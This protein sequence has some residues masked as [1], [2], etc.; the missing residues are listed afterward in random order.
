MRHR[1][2]T[3]T[4]EVG[5]STARTLTRVAAHL[6]LTAVLVVGLGCDAVNYKLIADGACPGRRIQ[7]ARIRESG[8]APRRSPA[9]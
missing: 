8:G 5:V 9:A 6:N 7:I 4:I 2:S 3:S 1:I